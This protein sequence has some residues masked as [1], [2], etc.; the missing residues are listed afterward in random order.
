MQNCYIRINF[1]NTLL[2][3]FFKTGRK[4]MMK[5]QTVGFLATIKLSSNDR[6]PSTSTNTITK[7]SRGWPTN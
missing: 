3:K 1:A 5:S 6:F 4:T 2:I 7:I